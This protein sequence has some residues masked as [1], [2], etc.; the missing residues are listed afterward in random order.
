MAGAIA[1][2]TGLSTAAVAYGGGQVI[3]AFGY[4]A[5]FL[6]SAG[7][8]AIGAALL[9]A[10][11]WLPRYVILRQVELDTTARAWSFASFRSFI[12]VQGRSRFP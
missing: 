2:T 11:T 10:F 4:Q 6:I 1:M 8:T 3:T 5:L 12:R 9:W 7:L